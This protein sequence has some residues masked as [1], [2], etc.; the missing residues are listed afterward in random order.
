M[1]ETTK[2]VRIMDLVDKP[3]AGMRVD[4]RSRN[5]DGS[6]MYEHQEKG[7]PLIVTMKSVTIDRKKD[8]RWLY[9]RHEKDCSVIPWDCGYSGH[10]IDESDL[11]DV[12]AYHLEVL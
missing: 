7:G 2:L 3:V 5:A 9:W 10:R 6:L 8:G 12:D 1:S 11:S 4:I